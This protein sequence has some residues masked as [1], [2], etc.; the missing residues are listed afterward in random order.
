MIDVKRPASVSSMSETARVKSRSRTAM[1]SSASPISGAI[2]CSVAR[3]YSSSTIT[4][5]RLLTRSGPSSAAASSLILRSASSI[6]SS[7]VSVRRML[8]TATWVPSASAPVIAA[9]AACISG[10]PRAASICAWVSDPKSSTCS[11]APTRNEGAA[12]GFAG[13]SSPPTPGSPATASS[14]ASIWARPA[15]VIASPRKTRVTT[16]T[17]PA[18]LKVSLIS[19]VAAA[20]GCPGG[21]NATS[22]PSV[23]GSRSVAPA[24]RTTV[25]AAR[26][27]SV[28]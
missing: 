11:A 28:T 1:S 20:T 9:R 14:R 13:A 10:A 17:S 6:L 24:A 15:G 18:A 3:V 21:R 22:A 19:R 23:G 27:S 7:P 26:T 2:P 12:T 5:D 4:G 25:M 8:A 16:R